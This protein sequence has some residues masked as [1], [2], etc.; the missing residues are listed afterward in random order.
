MI[1][2]EAKRGFYVPLKV[3]EA[4]IFLSVVTFPLVEKPLPEGSGVCHLRDS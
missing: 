1:R 4:V 2:T 3:P